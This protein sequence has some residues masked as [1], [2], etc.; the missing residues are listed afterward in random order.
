VSYPPAPVSIADKAAQRLNATLDIQQVAA[1]VQHIAP[2][3]PVQ[4]SGLDRLILFAALLEHD[5]KI[6]QAKAAIAT[7]QAEARAS[8]RTSGPT[9]TL[10]SEY[11]NDTSARSPP[12]LWGG[13]VDL[14][15]DV[16]GKRKARL[17]RADLAVIAA[18]YGY[19]ETLWGERMA[20][21]HALIDAAIATRQVALGNDIV[22][23]RDRQMAAMQRQVT[24]GELAGAAL[25]PNRVFREQEMRALEDARARLVAAK[26]TLAG[27]LAMPVSALGDMPLLWPEF[28]TPDANLAASVT[29]AMR[30]QAL[31][32]RADILQTLTA[33]DQT[34]A[35]V[36]LEIS[37]QY[38]G[39][40]LAPGYTW[41]RGLVKL[42]L[43]INLGLPSF[44]LN[45]SAIHAALARRDEAGAAIET[46]IANAQTEM[47]AAL[48]E[49]TAAFSALKRL[50]ESELPQTQASASRADAQLAQGQSA[51]SDWADAQIS[52]L[53]AR[54]TALDALA[55]V[56]TAD[57]ALEN[58]LRRPL[59]GPEMMIVPQQLETK[60]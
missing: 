37:R 28:D 6:A 36:H 49:R 21:R 52:A 32:A 16:G 47:D 8:R 53:A 12:W 54:L 3:A 38:P 51:R 17:G 18:Q 48:V 20:L 39:I 31:S 35:D 25:A 34:D 42:P 11:A 26:S 9:F 57:A 1:P 10:S 14:P 46:A 15:L 59:Q 27:I 19:A 50:T 43:S 33:Y 45:K 4:S 13:A 40:S 2:D 7:A 58:A 5:P 23:L 60:P 44:D 41:E 24:S 22:A 30:E 56:Q 55:R 29:P